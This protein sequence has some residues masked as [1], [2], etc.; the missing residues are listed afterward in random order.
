MTAYYSQCTDCGWKA[1]AATSELLR[2]EQKAHEFGTPPLGAW[3]HQTTSGKETG[4]MPITLEV[5]PWRLYT[6]N[7][8]EMF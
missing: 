6:Q 4:D 3:G 7:D 1:I 2:D 8:T 5:L